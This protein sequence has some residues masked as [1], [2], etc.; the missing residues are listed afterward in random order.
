MIR[1]PDQRLRVFISSTIEELK[2]ERKALREAIEGLRLTPVFFEAGARPH[3]P[4][5]LYRA[6]LDQSDIFIGI[7]AKSYGWVAPDMTISGLEDEYR[8]CGSKP[9]LIYIKE[10]EDEREERLNTLLRDIR[11]SGAMSYQKFRTPENLAEL[12]RNDLA[13]LLS[14]RFTQGTARTEEHAPS[15]SRLPALRGAS[16]GRDEDRDAI[17]AL[18]LR[19]DVGLVTVTGAGG[20]GKSRI[21]L[22]VAHTVQAHFPDGALF[23][24]LASVDRPEL[25]ASTIAHALGSY[26]NARRSATD[27]L[28]DLLADKR[29]LLVLD[30]FEQVIDAGPMLS[31]LVDHC[32]GLKVLV[33]SRT[34]LHL[35]AEQV[36]PLSPLAEPEDPLRAPPEELRACSSVELFIERARSVDPGLRL[37]EPDLRAIATI[38]QRLNGLPLAIELAAQQTRM[39]P[40]EAL[41]QRMDNALGMLSA[42]VRDMPERQRTMRATIAWSHDLLDPL[43]RT[44]LRRLAVM[45]DRFLLND[46]HAVARVAADEMA[47]TEV[48]ERLIDQGLVRAFPRDA[49]GM[50]FSLLH[51]VREFA[52]EEL[53]AAGERAAIERQH[54]IH[55]TGLAERLEDEHIAGASTDWLRLLAAAQADMRAAFWHWHA[56]GDRAGMWRIIAA[57]RGVWAYVGHVGEA[58]EW[59]KAAGVDPHGKPPDVDEQ[60]QARTRVAAGLVRTIACDFPEAEALL[61]S[62][63]AYM[64]QDRPNVLLPRALIYLGFVLVNMR[65]VAA[66]PYL[67]RAVQLAKAAN[68]DFELCFALTPLSEVCAMEGDM[69]AAHNYLDQAREV[70]ERGS[71]GTADGFY[72]LQAGNLA[73]MEGRY[74]SAVAD[75]EQGIKG[76][77]R[78][79]MLPMSGWNHWGIGSARIHM[80]DVPGARAAFTAALDRARRTSDLSM[81]AA[82]LLG[83]AMAVLHE[84]DPLRA[85]RIMGHGEHLA[86][87]SG[88]GFWGPDMELYRELKEEL[89]KALDAEGVQQAVAEGRALPL[90]KAIALC[91]ARA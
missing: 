42:T 33:S 86:E 52:Y 10:I 69:K 57:Q 31:E 8:L 50:R 3:P 16:V 6:Y 72:H 43:A 47:T 12:I 25:V 90:D 74:E 4:R 46:A 21:T 41:L 32:A 88:Y 60:L 28:F 19:Q 63:L 73:L 24:P 38:C 80:D 48:L 29:M 36:Y 49:Q 75:L 44:L 18:L 62:A 26:D 53:D 35:R 84:G 91:A 61:R 17:V 56:R 5:E 9:K 51:V 83:L 79:H 27:L 55:F 37:N 70:K 68:D 22:L 82:S 58:M 39:F 87:G 11:S 66:K 59:I 13:I 2:E 77:D 78:V 85:A 34:P 30:N 89:H 7:Y 20:T 64:E 67:E 54:A 40:P 14:E 45:S 76:F 23:V 1:T 65:N 15:F 71:A 81:I